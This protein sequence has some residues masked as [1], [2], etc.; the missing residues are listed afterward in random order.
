MKINDQEW[1][2]PNYQVC[3]VCCGDKTNNIWFVNGQCRLDQ[4]SYLQVYN[5]LQSNRRAKPDLLRITNDPNLV[6]LANSTNLKVPEAEAD[7]SVSD[8]VN[9]NTIPFYTQFRGNI[10]GSII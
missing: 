4:L 1:V 5:I 8:L 3:T 9:K 7:K 6:T 2:N 10:D